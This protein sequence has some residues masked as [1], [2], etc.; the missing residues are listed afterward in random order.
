MASVVSRVV[1][2]RGWPAALADLAISV[3]QSEPDLGGLDRALQ[4]GEVI[5]SYAFRGGSYVFDPTVGAALLSVRTA[6][7]VWESSRWQQQGAFS[8][9]DWEP[10]RETMSEVLSTGPMTRE[11]ISAQLGGTRGLEHLAAA[12]LGTGADSLYKPLHW[13]GDICFGPTRDGQTT[14]RSL[15]GDPRWPGLDDVDQA[16]RRAVA[17]YLGAYGPATADNLHYWLTEGLGAP[18]RRMLGWLSDLG[19]VVTDLTVDGATS[20]LLS[21]DLDQLS[22][23]EPSDA[24]NLLPGFD[25]WVMGPGTA[26]SRIIAP[27][28]RAL[29]SRGANLV[30]RGG[31]VCGTWRSQSHEVNVSWFDEAGSAP[32][33]ALEEQVQRLAG[34]RARELKLTIA[35]A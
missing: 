16:G 15:R 1:A 26:D 14:F 22:K 10:L 18:R 30:I 35:N 19:D 27:A 17:L 6:T 21:A 7:K 25:P 29:A 34:S 3:R 5:R 23:T 32:A 24:V 8:V 11:E 33:A 20:Y 13:W 4:D 9:D 12:A 31:V 2:L 28:R